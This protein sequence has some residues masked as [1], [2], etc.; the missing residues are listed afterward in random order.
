MFI[1]DMQAS[2][3]TISALEQ[4]MGGHLQSTAGET[5]SMGFLFRGSQLKTSLADI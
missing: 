1:L 5:Y 3:Q 2:R 4:D